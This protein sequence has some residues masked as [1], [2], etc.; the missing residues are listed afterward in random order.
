MGRS[1]GRS[2]CFPT[3][4]R[5]SM[6]WRAPAWDV[7]PVAPSPHTH[8][9][10]YTCGA[11]ELGSGLPDVPPWAHPAV[12]DEPRLWNRWEPTKTM[13]FAY[14]K[15]IASPRPAEKPGRGRLFERNYSAGRRSNFSK[16]IITPPGRPA[17]APWCEEAWGILRTPMAA[18]HGSF[19]RSWKLL[20]PTSHEKYSFRELHEHA[21]WCVKL[22]TTVFTRFRAE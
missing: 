16:S 6:R 5:A 12:T 4:P 18:T 15:S 7:L 8:T 20:R 17:A 3:P 1:A 22:E 14:P 2:I 9:H 10:T 13:V 21:P 19:R 11:S